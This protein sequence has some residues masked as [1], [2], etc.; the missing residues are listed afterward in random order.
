MFLNYAKCLDFNGGR[1]P[2]AAAQIGLGFRNEIAPR[3]GLVRVREFQMAEIEHF[4]DPQDKS[5]PKF[6]KHAHLPLPL[7]SA[8]NQEKLEQL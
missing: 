1:I 8:Q 6:K 5:H 7:L 3:S 2:F 4:I